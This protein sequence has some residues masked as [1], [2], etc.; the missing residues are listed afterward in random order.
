MHITCTVQ[1]GKANMHMCVVPVVRLLITFTGD[2]SEPRWKGYLYAALLFVTAMIQSL[3]LHQYFH[4]CLRLGMRMRSAIVDAVYKKVMH[5]YYGSHHCM[6]LS[7]TIS[8]FCPFHF[9]SFPL[10][11]SSPFPSSPPTSPLPLPHSSYI[12][13]SPS[14][15]PSSYTCIYPLSPPLLFL[16][17]P[18]LPFPTPPTHVHGTCIYPLS[19]PLLFLPL[20]LPSPSPLPSLLSPVTQ[21]QQQITS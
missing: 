14:L 12:S 13:S 8:P 9:L 19:P 11:L 6:L 21:S 16:P 4:R 1:I 5:I 10:H 20:P 2:E 15:P 3:F 18:F 7:T 17:L